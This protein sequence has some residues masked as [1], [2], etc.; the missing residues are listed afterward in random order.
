[1]NNY[2]VLRAV[3]ASIFTA[4]LILISKV[5][6][7]YVTD[8][9]TILATMT[10]SFLDISASFINFIA[11]KYALQPADNEHRF[12]HGKAEDLAVFTQSTF[13]GL[14]GL[15]IIVIAVKR[16]VHPEVTKASGFGI[17]VMVF[18][19]FA[20]LLLIIYQTYSY[21]KTSSKILKAD[22]LHYVIDLFTNVAVIASL[23]LSEKLASKIIDPIFAICIALY[24]LYGAW[25]LLSSA[26]H[27]LLDHE[28]KSSEKDKLHEVIMSHKKVQGYHD[29]KTRYA[30]RHSFIQFHL[31]LE[32]KMT[33]HE[34]H[35]ISEE[36]EDRILKEFKRAEVII[37]QDP[38]ELYGK[39]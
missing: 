18:S 8:S 35:D 13:F 29:L 33:L 10:D 23:Y 1:M 4:I 36:I 37:H 3:S 6:A 16:I 28:F 14:S 5:V 11:A 25:D 34:S 9:P 2:L 21:R 15:F 7:W 39:E 12:G 27:N 26:F 30:G 38:A 20:T 22:R 17:A 32:G 19:I 24:L 31:E